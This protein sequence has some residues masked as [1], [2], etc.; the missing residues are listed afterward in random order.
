MERLL[1]LENDASSVCVIDMLFYLVSNRGK[2]VAMYRI[3]QTIHKKANAG[4]TRA[5]FPTY[6]VHLSSGNLMTLCETQVNITTV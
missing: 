2:V 1:L 5:S 6:C 3:Y 4:V